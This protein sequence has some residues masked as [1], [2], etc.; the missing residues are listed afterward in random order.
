MNKLDLILVFI[1]VALLIAAFSPEVVSPVQAAAVDQAALPG[2]AN[3]AQVDLAT[4]ETNPV[5]YLA[6]GLMALL[7]GGL[8]FLP[9]FCKEE[10]KNSASR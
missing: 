6:A 2:E 3:A 8:T 5:T 9:L 7:F 4:N 10:C 1:I